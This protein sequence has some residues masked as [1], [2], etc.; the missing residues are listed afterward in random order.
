[1]RASCIGAIFCLIL[2]ACAGVH[3]EGT[4]DLGIVVERDTGSVQIINTTSRTALG[5]VSGLGDLTHA[6]VVYSRDG[7]YAYVFGRDGGLSK[8]DLLTRRINKRVMQAGNS[9]G[10][11]ISQ[12]GR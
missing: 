7:R 8:V 4:G 10:G 11:A 5:R 3:L 12:N 1:M 2:T 9:I 6:S